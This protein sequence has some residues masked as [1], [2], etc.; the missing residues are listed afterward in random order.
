MTIATVD[1]L[2]TFGFVMVAE[3]KFGFETQLVYDLA[4]TKLHAD[5]CL[6]KY[7]RPNLYFSGIWDTGRTLGMTEF[8]MPCRLASHEQCAALLAYHLGDYS[9]TAGDPEP[10]W[11]VTGRQRR[12]L[13]PWTIDAAARHATYDALP[14]CF[15]ERNWLRMALKTLAAHISEKGDA[16]P[17]TFG[18]MDDILSISWGDQRTVVSAKGKPWPQSVVIS[19]HDLRTL[20]KRL[21]GDE[22]CILVGD[23]HLSIGN[24]SFPRT[25]ND[26]SE[27]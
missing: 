4:G 8:T 10:E 2:Q 1:A 17:V 3:P 20:P 11:L 21:I 22:I 26:G 14:K 15:V 27:P 9:H 24:R 18:F 12:D 6:D 7:E 19:S 5:I 16:T 25:I 13:L 23:T